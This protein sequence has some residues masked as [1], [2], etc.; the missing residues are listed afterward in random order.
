LAE[1]QS[2]VASNDMLGA[3]KALLELVQAKDD[4]AEYWTELGKLQASMGAYSDAYYAFTRAYELDRSNPELAR[5]LTQLALRSGDLTTAQARAEEL[6][7]LVPGDPWVKLAKGW[8]AVGESRFGQSLPIADQLLSQ[9]PLDPA[10]TVLKGRSLFGLGREDEAIDFLSK[11]VAAM[12]S[13]TGSLNLLAQ[14]YQRRD[15]WVKV[16]AVRRQL[17][18]LMPNDQDNLLALVEASLRSGQIA[19][20]RAASFRLLQPQAPRGLVSKVLD[21]WSDFWPS[22]ERVEDARKLAS[23]APPEQRL[24]YA[25][26]LSSLGSPAD[27]IRLTTPDATLPVR[28]ENAEANAVFADAQLRSGNLSAAKSRLDA[29]IAYDPGNATALRARA[30]LELRTGRAP[31]A[32]NDA[33]KLVTVVPSSPENRILLARAYTAA[34]NKTWA[35][36]TLWAAFND[37]PAND[38]VYEALRSTRI[39]KPDA[40]A[41]LEAEFDRQR[42]HQIRKGLL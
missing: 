35:D 9:N 18:Q 12:R 34:G 6:E 33:Q 21:L 11:H 8:A 31:Q 38:R 1:Y 17:S 16:V 20:A 3:R 15:E 24:V 39:G 5:A 40:L 28:A 32:I 10:A 36:R 23:K 19:D 42:D 41:Q 29:V 14:I 37:I 2:A 4:V 7:V 27:A 26:F 30:E 25:A 13:D 22:P